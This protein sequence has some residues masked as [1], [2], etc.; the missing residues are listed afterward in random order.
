MGGRRD[1]ALLF[2]FGT[3]RMVFKAR[4]GVKTRGHPEKICGW[5]E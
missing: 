4:V 3:I 2:V 1:M 5:I